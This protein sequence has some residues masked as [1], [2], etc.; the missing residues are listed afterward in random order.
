MGSAVRM[1]GAPA[2]SST[3]AAE[4]AWPTQV[5]AI[6]GLHERHRVVDGEQADHVAAGR[7]DVEVD[8]LV[9]VLGLEEQQLGDDQVGD[10]VV[11]RRAQEHDAFAQQPGVDVVGPLAAV[12]CSR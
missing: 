1:P 12:A 5:V 8:R 10:L 4:A 11:D 3:A 6:G 9:G 7:V 2:A